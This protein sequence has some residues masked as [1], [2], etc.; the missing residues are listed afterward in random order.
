MES[1]EVSIMEKKKKDS[2]IKRPRVRGLKKGAI[3]AM[4]GKR[5]KPFVMTVTTVSSVHA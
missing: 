1:K 3:I 5:K 4:A 2:Q